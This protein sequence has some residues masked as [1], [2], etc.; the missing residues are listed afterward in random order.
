MLI[1]KRRVGERIS[2]TTPS[3]ERVVVEVVEVCDRNS[4]RVGI[5]AALDVELLREELVVGGFPE[6]KAGEAKV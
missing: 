2:A 1:L 4:I 5:T 3:G 6:R